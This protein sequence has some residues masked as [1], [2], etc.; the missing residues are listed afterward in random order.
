MARLRSDAARNREA[1]LRAARS[2]LAAGDRSLRMHGVA[3][4]AGVGVGTTYRH[5]PTRQAL[6]DALALDRLEDLVAQVQQTAASVDPGGLHRAL[7]ALVEAGD[8]PTVAEVLS[9]GC[10]PGTPTA[11]LL[12]DFHEALDTLL[13][14]AREAGQIRPDVDG[15]DLRRLVCGVQHAL[16]VGQDREGLTALYSEVLL[17]GLR[18]R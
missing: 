7:C 17:A 12:L 4:D 3:R 11:A 16:H 10:T 13:Q 6:L 9:G 8:D 14:R 5:F 2:Q 18:P 1:L 15:D